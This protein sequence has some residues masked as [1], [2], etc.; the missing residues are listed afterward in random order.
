MTKDKIEVRI[1]AMNTPKRVKN[2]N[3]TY[4]VK[5]EIC[6]NSEGLRVLSSGCCEL[7]LKEK[8]NE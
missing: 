3:D 1:V 6:I 4:D 8:V 2:E 7:T 5:I